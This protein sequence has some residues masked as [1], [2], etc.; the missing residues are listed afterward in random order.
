TLKLIVA[1]DAKGGEIEVRTDKDHWFG[2]TRDVMKTIWSGGSSNAEEGGWW[3]SHSFRVNH[4]EKHFTVYQHV[5]RAMRAKVE[6]KLSV[7]AAAHDKE[8]IAYE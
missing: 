3:K 1:K 6:E 4:S 5:N 2:W 8:I 7:A